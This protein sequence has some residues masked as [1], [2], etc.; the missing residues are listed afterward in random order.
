MG[1]YNPTGQR[2]FPRGMGLGLTPAQEKKMVAL[3]RASYPQRQAVMKSKLTPE[4]KRIKLQ[5]IRMQFRSK[6]N[7][8]LT[9][10]QRKKRDAMMKERRRMWQQRET[11]NHAA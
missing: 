6:M 4:Q 3:M 2:R 1:N 10:T 7:A 8:I 5:A 11:E 9:P